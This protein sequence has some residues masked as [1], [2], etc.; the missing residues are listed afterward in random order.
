MKNI[1]LCLILFLF[2]KTVWGNWMSRVESL[3]CDASRRTTY[4]K[5]EYCQRNHVDC[6]RLPKKFNCRYFKER[7]VGADII[8]EE[9]ASKKSIYMESRAKM[10]D[11]VKSLDNRNQASLT[12]KCALI[13]DTD[14]S[15]FPELVQYCQ[16]NFSE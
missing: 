7:V 2:S 9:D 13:N 14:R 5:L 16:V 6:I 10:K 4:T 8:L 12:R 3:Q 11:V 15:M 1:F